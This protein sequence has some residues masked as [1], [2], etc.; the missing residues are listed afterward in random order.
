M[1]LFLKVYDKDETE[2]LAPEERKLLTQL[3]KSLR[4][5]ALQRK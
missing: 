4:D 5:A 1:I 2:D 3:A